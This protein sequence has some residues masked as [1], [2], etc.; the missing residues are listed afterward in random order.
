MTPAT[1]GRAFALPALLFLLLGG[2]FAM[3]ERTVFDEP[4]LPE[5]VAA[6]R[7]GVTT[8][9]EILAAFGPPR[10]VARPGT[11]MTFPPPG[12]WRAG[13]D[14]VPSE[15]FLALFA[16]RRPLRPSEV[17]FYYDAPVEAANQFLV[18]PLI[19]GGGVMREAV[20]DR[21]FLLVDEGTGRVEDLVFRR[22]P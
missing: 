12:G 6:I 3:R 19:G 4:L 10:A 13:G 20:V 7:P 22:A 2:C 5:R 16:A 15:A 17:V 18:F 8:R 21:L 11:Q 14:S 9:L 1:L